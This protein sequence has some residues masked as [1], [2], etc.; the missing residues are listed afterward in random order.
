MEATHLFCALDVRRELFAHVNKTLNAELRAAARTVVLWT[1]GFAAV[2][3]FFASRSVKG[4]VLRR[5]GEGTFNGLYRICF[6]GMALT[7]FTGLLVRFARLPD[8]QLYRV[9]LPWS[10]PMRLVQLASI[11]MLLDANVRIGVG[12]MSGLQGLWQWLRSETPIVQNPAQGPQLDGDAD[13]RTGGT[14][15]LSRHPNNLAPLVLWVAH[16][17]MTVRFAAFILVSA[18]Y[19]VLGSVH[20]EWRL[21]AAYGKRYDR[22]RSG[23]PFYLP[24]PR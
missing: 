8:R 18:L 5:Y 13:F 17:R 7:T 2:H 14:F 9:P 10:L 21:R 3:S 20:E 23:K 22:Y 4:W 24:L 15:R 12:R 6:N 11:A 1:A 16:P 19:L